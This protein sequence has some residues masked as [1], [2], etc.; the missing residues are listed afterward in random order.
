MH[1]TY[2]NNSQIEIKTYILTPNICDHSGANTLVKAN[3]TVLNIVPQTLNAN[4]T[5][6]KEMSKKWAPFNDWK[7][8]LNDTS[9]DNTKSISIA[10][11]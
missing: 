7:F 3:I 11:I 6:K 5:N 10:Y 1:G 9:A 4:Y 2:N 8:E